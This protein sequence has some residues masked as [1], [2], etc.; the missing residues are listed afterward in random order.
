MGEGCL[1]IEKQHCI[2]K[3][4]GKDRHKYLFIRGSSVGIKKMTFTILFT[5][6]I[7]KNGL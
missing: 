5:T 7:S 1:V 2:K 4:D 6:A 3:W